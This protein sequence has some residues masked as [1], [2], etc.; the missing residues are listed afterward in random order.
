MADKKEKNVPLLKEWHVEKVV[1]SLE[2][3]KE[4]PY[5]REKQKN[6][7]LT[8]Y[9]GKTEKSVFRGMVI[10]TLRKTGLIL[11]YEG[12]IRVSA[13]GRIAVESKKI[14][15]PLH[16]RAMQALI[17]DIDIRKFGFIK[18]LIDSESV[19]KIVSKEHFRKELAGKIVSPSYKQ[20]VERVNH[21][22]GM[23]KQV[24]LLKEDRFGQMSLNLKAHKQANDDLG[25]T[26]TKSAKFEK[27]LIESC[28]ELRRE[29]GVIIDI[30]DLREKV[31]IKLLNNDSEILTEYQFDEQLRY[32]LSTTDK[33][34][35][36]LGRP[37]GAEEKL[38]S[39]RDKYYRTLTME[40]ADG[41][42]E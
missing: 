12:F 5:S 3:I 14:S 1:C 36:S 2:C 16:L 39:F 21:W 4:H 24:E 28:I 8:L 33:Y 31:A 26:D 37:M 38:F 18:E 11:G 6:C 25:M 40:F 20:S 34:M 13:N 19:E 32:F 17:L 23:L 15:E 10:P 22:L 42:Q 41:R 9:P 29:T 7:I 35:I 30:A 27:Y